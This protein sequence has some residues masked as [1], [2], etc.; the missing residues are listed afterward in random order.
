M[1]LGQLKI[2]ERQAF[3]GGLSVIALKEVIMHC[4]RTIKMARAQKYLS[5]ESCLL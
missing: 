1:I 3:C 2:G 5:L 4:D